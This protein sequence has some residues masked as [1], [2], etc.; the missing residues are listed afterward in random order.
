VIYDTQL[1]IHILFLFSVIYDTQLII[2][3]FFL[4]PLDLNMHFTMA[5]LNHDYLLYIVRVVIICFVL[6][7]CSVFIIKMD[8][9]RFLQD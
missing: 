9:L 5:K 7:L 3:I 1:T 8:C 2:H 4:L 6:K